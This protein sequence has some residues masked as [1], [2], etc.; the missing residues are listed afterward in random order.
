MACTYIDIEP[1]YGIFLAIALKPRDL[2]LKL[3]VLLL[4]LR[5]RSMI[6]LG[7]LTRLRSLLLRVWV[8][9]K[10]RRILVGMLLLLLYSWVGFT[11]LY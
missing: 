2:R 9:G 6:S 5:T 8:L 4:T 1:Y 10:L 7:L 11:I 3:V